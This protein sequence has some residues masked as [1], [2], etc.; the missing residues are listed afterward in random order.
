MGS[1]NRFDPDVATAPPEVTDSS[2]IGFI[3]QQAVTEGVDPSYY[4]D[5]TLDD[6]LQYWVAGVSGLPPDNV[7]PRYQEQ[8][9]TY[10]VDA[11]GNGM[12]FA[13]IGVHGDARPLGYTY[14]QYNSTPAG[15]GSQDRVGW[16]EFD[17]L[18]SFFGKKAGFYSTN[19]KMGAEVG[20]NFE[21]LALVQMGL[22]WVGP[23]R[24]APMLIKSLWTQRY[25]VMV[26]MQRA[27]ITNYPV[28]YFLSA[29]IA[30]T[31]DSGFTSNRTAG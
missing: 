20:N 7:R 4:S 31:T 29:P 6:F 25:D 13:A 17:L 26:T 10:P 19:F 21:G 2:N 22:T 23:R 15:L 30:V 12:D 24:R 16:E 5:G 8:Q 3:Q 1:P 28:R 27:I 11:N 18:C 14:G 9:P